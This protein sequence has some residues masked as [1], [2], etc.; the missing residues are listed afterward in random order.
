MLA[1][2]TEYI[3]H[4]VVNHSYDK[5]LGFWTHR[6]NVFNIFSNL[7]KYMVDYILSILFMLHSFVSHIVH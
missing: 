2:D 3:R 1:S 6:L 4:P 7:N 5:L